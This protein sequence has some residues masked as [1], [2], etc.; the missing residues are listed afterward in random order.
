MNHTWIGFAYVDRLTE[1]EINK[2]LHKDE[3]Y[4]TEKS[5]FATAYELITNLYVGNQRFVHCEIVFPMTDSEETGEYL[6]YGVFSNVG[7]FCKKRTY[8]NPAY[9]II[10]LRISPMESQIARDFCAPLVGKPFDAV[11]MRWSPIWPQKVDNT[12]FY[13]ISFSMTVLRRI[14]ILKTYP[15]TSLDTDD[16]VELLDNHP[17]KL[18]G[19]MS[20][21]I[22][23]H[24]S[25]G[26][27]SLF[28]KK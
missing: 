1:M 9:R 7:V 3:K 12:R 10:Y 20:T 5:A 13:C 25:S 4:N 21:R 28:D 18:N 17:R 22:H 27:L 24:R 15:P 26:T 14:G 11:G 6:A 8:K 16:I 19:V 2:E 23:T